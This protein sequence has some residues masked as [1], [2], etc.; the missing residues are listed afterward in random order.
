[1]QE[2]LSVTTPGA[3]IK[4]VGLAGIMLVIAVLSATLLGAIFSSPDTYKSAYAKL[5]EKRNNV[6][7]LTVTATATSCALTAVPDD[8]GTP[9][10]NQLMALAKDFAIVLAVIVLEKYLLTI[11]GLAFFRLVIPLCC[12]LVAV[13]EFLSPANP[14][15]R[16]YKQAALKF[17][18]LGLILFL[19]TPT[20]VLVAGM[21]DDTYQASIDA[22]NEQKS[23]IEDG[24]KEQSESSETDSKTSKNKEASNP[25]EFIQN[26]GSDVANNV[27]SAVEGATH[28]AADMVETAG[29]MVGNMIELFGVMIATSV[30]I[31]IISPIVMYLAFKTLFGQ[32][33]AAA[34]Q[35]VVL[36]S[37]QAKKL[38]S[39][40]HKPRSE[41]E[42]AEATESEGDSE[43]E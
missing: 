29:N 5:N 26:V 20:S 34:T 13:S 11:F 1:M 16:I 22:V 31:P 35:Q 24:A 14:N 30:L 10:A 33:L 8:F 43:E 21:I 39:S 12:L 23:E 3:R 32:Q 25:L 2:E 37:D 19:S 36:L 6:I 42:L 7:A 18:T 41:R 27:G 17:F 38:H 9:V 15:R 40:I 28:A 4:P